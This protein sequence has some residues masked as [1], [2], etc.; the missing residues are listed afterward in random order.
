M[1]ALVKTNRIDVSQLVATIR[2]PENIS[3]VE[4]IKD[5]ELKA[6]HGARLDSLSHWI[7]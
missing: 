5:D 2:Q 7:N 4:F 3:K 1:V 6:A